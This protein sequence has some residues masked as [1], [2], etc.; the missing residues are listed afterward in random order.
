MGPQPSQT[1]VAAALVLSEEFRLPETRTGTRLAVWLNRELT[2]PASSLGDAIREILK[3]L[4]RRRKDCCLL[5]P[6]EVCEHVAD[7]LIAEILPSCA[8][9]PGTASDSSL[10]VVGRSTG[11]YGRGTAL[12]FRD[13]HKAFLTAFLALCECLRLSESNR[14][15]RDWV[16]RSGS[17]VFEKDFFVPACNEHREE[18]HEAIDAALAVWGAGKTYRIVFKA[19]DFGSETGDE[20]ADR[21]FYDLRLHLRLEH[22]TGVQELLEAP[23]NVKCSKSKRDNLAGL[24]A[25]VWTMC[26]A[27]KNFG[28]AAAAMKAMRESL[29]TKALVPDSDYFVLAFEKQLADQ[30]PIARY[31]V[32]SLLGTA[33]AGSG[34]HWNPAQP[35]PSIQ[36]AYDV[37]EGLQRVE[38]SAR[39]TRQRL[40]DW[41]LE[42]KRAELREWQTVVS[43][44]PSGDK[45]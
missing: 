43:K 39:A 31:H 20:A 6:I 44:R 25:F 15:G 22:A 1:E 9:L 5:A 10:P 41:W 27:E 38:S 24:T 30:P 34:L 2:N 45:R 29:E 16:G 14:P 13:F 42:H 40:M 21:A 33:P 23:A 37:A 4:G 35:V 7:D 12:P 32:L 8:V 26:G 36:V 28:R 17:K 19:L 11:S 18:I 3:P